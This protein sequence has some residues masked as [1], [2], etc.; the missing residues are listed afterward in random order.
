MDTKIELLGQK[1]ASFFLIKAELQKKK[2]LEKIGKPEKK[3]TLD[4][5]RLDIEKAMSGELEAKAK[6]IVSSSNQGISD[7]WSEGL[8]LEALRKKVMALSIG[9]RERFLPLIQKYAEDEIHA[10]QLDVWNHRCDSIDHVIRSYQSNFPKPFTMKMVNTDPDYPEERIGFSDN[11]PFDR[12]L[13]N[14]LGSSKPIFFEPHEVWA[15]KMAE[16]YQL[17][18][19]EFEK[20]KA[21]AA[22]P[23][24]PPVKEAPPPPSDEIS[25]SILRREF[26]DIGGV[27]PE[28]FSR[29][30]QRIYKGGEK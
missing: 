10:R 25:P 20:E 22:A 30:S 5:F 19:K 1:G 7:S 11:K 13:T 28:P 2:E 18:V 17:Y 12:W 23:P 26:Y 9:E 24:P 4:S 3:V 16:A 8:F 21:K 14:A 6:N 27:Q 15:E 29:R